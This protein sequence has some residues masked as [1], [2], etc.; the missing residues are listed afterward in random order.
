MRDMLDDTLNSLQTAAAATGNGTQLDVHGYAAVVVQV[1]GTFSATLTPEITLDG[2]NWVTAEGIKVADSSRASTV[3]AAG[4]YVFPVLGCEYFRLRVSGYV[5]GSVTAK[6]RGISGAAGALMPD[7][8]LSTGAITVGTVDQ[9]AA[10]SASW[11][12]TQAT[13][14][15]GVATH[16]ADN[17]VTNASEAILAA[18]VDRKAAIIQVV[19]GGNARV[20]IG[21]T[22]TTTLGVQL[23]AGGPPLILQA[24]F[25]PT[26][27]INA[28]REGASDAV[29][30][31]VEIA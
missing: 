28:I 17:T 29:I 9:G 10:G 16:T 12:V 26:V 6:A 14:T 25:C 8:Q 5:S 2:T 23:A 1:T 21:V 22:A 13:N 4:I 27:A 24:P 7:V 3:T 15:A 18:N 20:A 30:Q 11:K 31:V 19:S